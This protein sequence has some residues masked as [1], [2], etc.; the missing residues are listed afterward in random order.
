[1]KTNIKSLPSTALKT[2]LMAAALVSSAVVF[3]QALAEAHKKM[4]KKP[5]SEAMQYDKFRDTKSA[6]QVRASELIGE[7]VENAK[8]DEI[9]EIDDLVYSRGDNQLYAIIS[10]GGFLGMGERLVVVPYSD[11]RVS[12][13]GDDVYLDATENSLKALPE[14]KYIDGEEMGNAT[15]MKRNDIKTKEKKEN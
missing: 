12:A 6:Y 9:G 10:V 14:F 11:L 1:M 15:V 5:Y 7:D 8:D 13:D 3:N 2:T 4:E